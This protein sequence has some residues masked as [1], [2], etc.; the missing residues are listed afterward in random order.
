VGVSLSPRARRTRL[1]EGQAQVD[2]AP[3]TRL[4]KSRAA[5]GRGQQVEATGLVVVA[6]QAP[7]AARIELAGAGQLVVRGQR[8]I[9]I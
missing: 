9:E 7:R 3:V 2:R 8:T 1:I 4:S 5:S 6:E